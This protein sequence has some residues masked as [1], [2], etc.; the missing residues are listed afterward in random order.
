MR[1]TVARAALIAAAVAAV[2]GCAPAANAAP[3]AVPSWHIVTSVH[4]GQLGNFTAVTAVGRSGGWAFNNGS[5]PTAWR[6][7][8]STWTQV[9]FPGLANE[10]V[11]A[12]GAASASEVWAFTDTGTH[13]R[14]LRWNGTTWTV[15]R[16]F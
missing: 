1:V 14:A 3:A 7:S 11:D 13:S 9:P 15:E 4:N 2:A 16:S 8:G 12:A 10:W 5:V 6:L